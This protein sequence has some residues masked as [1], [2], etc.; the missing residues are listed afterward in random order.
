MENM[1]PRTPQQQLWTLLSQKEQQMV[2]MVFRHLKK[3]DQQD[4]CYALIAYI[5]FGI[6]RHYSCPFMQ[7]AYLAFIEL[8]DN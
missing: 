3:R 2:R 8:I 5:R 7:C 4:L 6:V 1:K